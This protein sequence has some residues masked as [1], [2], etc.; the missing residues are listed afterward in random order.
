MT[1]DWMKDYEELEKEVERLRSY[2]RST[3]DAMVAMRNSINEIIPMPSIES[4]LLIGPENSVF[5]AAVVKGVADG[6][7]MVERAAIEAAAK[8]V[9]Y[10]SGMSVDDAASAVRA[11]KRSQQ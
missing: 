2:Q 6:V 8:V 10:S 7:I 1:D 5:F 3:F 9:S 4:D 11:L